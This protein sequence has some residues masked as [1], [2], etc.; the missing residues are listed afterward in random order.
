MIP[1]LQIQIKVIDI[2]PRKHQTELTNHLGHKPL[3]NGLKVRNGKYNGLYIS[4]L[5]GRLMRQFAV[6]CV[7]VHN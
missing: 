2:F 6:L 5:P 7:T 4:E 3:T 1:L